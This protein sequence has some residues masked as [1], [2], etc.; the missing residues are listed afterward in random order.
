MGVYLNQ[1]CHAYTHF[2]SEP[3]KLLQL[4]LD[5]VLLKQAFLNPGF[6]P[7]EPRQK[8]VH[9]CSVVFAL[10]KQYAGLWFVDG[11]DGSIQSFPPAAEHI[12]DRLS[13]CGDP[14]T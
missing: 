5:K 11:V 10:K 3:V 6:G 9:D 7:F 4:E 14:R 8:S 2:P 12:T 13:H 1:L